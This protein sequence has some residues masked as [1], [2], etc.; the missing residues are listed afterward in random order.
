MRVRDLAGRL[1]QLVRGDILGDETFFSE[2]AQEL[3]SVEDALRNAEPQDPPG[4]AGG[5]AVSIVLREARID[6]GRTCAAIANFALKP[7]DPDRLL[8]ATDIPPGVAA[9]LRMVGEASAAEVLDGVVTVLRQRFVGGCTRSPQTGDLELLAQAIAGIEMYLEDLGQGAAFGEDTLAKAQ[10]AMDGLA[11][12]LPAGAV[13]PIPV[14]VASRHEG[15]TPLAEHLV[16]HTDPESLEIFLDEAREE[17]ARIA[18][19][20]PGWTENPADSEAL[21][22]LQRTFHTLKGSSLLAGSPRIATLAAITETLLNRIR[23]GELPVTP[24]VTGYLAGV[25][26]LVPALIEAEATASVI[27]IEPQLAIAN[28]LL[29]APVAE[30]TSDRGPG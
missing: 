27:D 22:I 6:L 3:L 16:T 13:A 9:A 17:H 20:L 29:D 5:D 21:V 4:P 11:A 7:G 25:T 15:P 28:Q 19:A 26:R 14:A 18:H 2:F 1:G 30:G 24:A 12:S 10:S 23:G 8:D